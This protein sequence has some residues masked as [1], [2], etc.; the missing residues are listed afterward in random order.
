[1]SAGLRSG[2]RAGDAI[3]L[4]GMPEGEPAVAAAAKDADRQAHNIVP[5]HRVLGGRGYA[6]G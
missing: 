4:S 5:I 6:F 2:C 1:M 3:P